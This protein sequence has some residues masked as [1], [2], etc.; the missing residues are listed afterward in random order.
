MV[1]D[2]GYWRVTTK[3]GTI[4]LFDWVR[5]RY[6]KLLLDSPNKITGDRRWSRIAM[7]PPVLEIGKPSRMILEGK[8]RRLSAE[9]VSIEQV[10]SFD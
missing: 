5:K 8:D 2:R 1:A 10:E 7:P 3:H 6:T 9:V 4:H